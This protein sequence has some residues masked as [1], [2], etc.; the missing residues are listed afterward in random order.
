MF[1]VTVQFQIA[2]THEIEFLAHM[3]QNAAQSLG[4][5]PGCHQF[6]VCTDPARPCEVFL[7]EVYEDA[8]AFQDHLHSAHFKAF[9][10]VV[11]DMVLSKQ[12]ATFAEVWQ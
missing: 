11:A 12:V 6:D 4:A 10:A 1:V 3:R 7:Y 2:P 5:E 9:D 8:Q